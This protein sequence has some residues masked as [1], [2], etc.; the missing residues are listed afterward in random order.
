MIY[1]AL[2]PIVGEEL[3]VDFAD[4]ITRDLQFCWAPMF[5]LQERAKGSVG[6]I[7][8]AGSL[9]RHA[10]VTNSTTSYLS[11]PNVHV[12]PTECHA[13]IV[14]T[15]ASPRAYADVFASYSNT[16]PDRGGWTLEANASGTGANAFVRNLTTL[17]SSG[18]M[19]WK[20]GI[21]SRIHL[22]VVGGS[23]GA[24]YNGVD[25]SWTTATV[26]SYESSPLPFVIG[27]GTATGLK[28]HAAY[29]WGRALNDAE[30]RRLDDDPFCFLTANTFSN[31]FVASGGV[32]MPIFHHHYQNVLNGA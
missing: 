15:M 18:L 24:R 1:G 22:R 29:F 8:N 27:Q 11:F 5:G 32:V 10:Y 19:A 17:R 20:F 2:D 16:A 9:F 12:A 3:V 13:F 25:A 14:A 21:P 26:L 23:V 31:W 4:P 6:T 30:V 28:V 7:V